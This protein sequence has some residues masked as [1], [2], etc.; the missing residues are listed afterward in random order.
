MDGDDTFDW[1]ASDNRELKILFHWPFVCNKQFQSPQ[2]L[3][4]KMIILGSL[5]NFL[6]S[7]LPDTISP[8]NK[9]KTQ[10]RNWDQQCCKSIVI[11]QMDGSR[12]VKVMQ[13]RTHSS[14]EF[15]FFQSRCKPR[16]LLQSF[17]VET[18]GIK[19]IW[20]MNTLKLNMTTSSV[21]LIF[22]FF[23]NKSIMKISE[24]VRNTSAFTQPYTYFNG[25]SYVS[26]NWQ[27]EQPDGQDPIIV[28]FFHYVILYQYCHSAP[29]LEWLE[30][31][32]S[33]GFFNSNRRSECSN[34]LFVAYNW[35][36]EYKK[37]FNK[38]VYLWSFHM[39]FN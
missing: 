19:H 25:L 13:M 30:P 22:R 6:E 26:G 15:A 36:A 38:Y 35:M 17:R 34:V 18:I 31:W 39:W 4:V 16:G 3:T 29:K 7:P 2:L 37:R 12:C 8:I 28:S 5:Q 23:I 24:I 11:V 21:S 20:L 32:I 1:N 33:H 9:E 27:W 14:T 10:F